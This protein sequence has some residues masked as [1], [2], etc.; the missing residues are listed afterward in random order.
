MHEGHVG[1]GIKFDD[2]EYVGRGKDG[3]GYIAAANPMKLQ[4]S[5]R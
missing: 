3:L 4:D 5:S 1:V 2:S